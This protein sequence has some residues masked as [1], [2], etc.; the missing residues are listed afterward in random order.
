M[1]PL[2]RCTSMNVCAVIVFVFVPLAY[3]RVEAV[4][5]VIYVFLAL[6]Y[7]ISPLS[8]VMDYTSSQMSSMSVSEDVIVA[9]ETEIARLQSELVAAKRRRNSFAL[10]C[11][12]PSEII[13]LI[14]SH[15]QVSKSKQPVE[16]SRAGRCDFLFDFSHNQQWEQAMMASSRIHEIAMSTP[17]LW[18]YINPSSGARLGHDQ[19]Q[20]PESSSFGRAPCPRL[21][22]EILRCQPG[23]SEPA[24]DKDK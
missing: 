18:T 1:L 20:R 8:M 12:L 11:A 19:H 7:T 14:L 3:L 13:I 15:T 22:Q 4:V 16:I 24:L 9:L 21:F 6:S 10:L 5:R 23:C 17:E 2:Y